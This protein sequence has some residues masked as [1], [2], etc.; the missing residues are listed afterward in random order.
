MKIVLLTF[1][2]L[3]ILVFVSRAQVSGF[4]KSADSLM[5][6]LY[7]EKLFSGRVLVQKSGITLY[8]GDF[9]QISSSSARYKIGSVSKVCTAIMV[10]QLIEEGKLSE[11]MTIE[12]FFPD[13]KYAS[14]ITVEQ[15]LSHSSGI[16][17]IT[18]WEGYYA[19]RN[20]Q[21]S[22]QEILDLIGAHKPSFKP[23]EDCDYSN[24]NYI[25]LGYMMEDITGKT[26]AANLK[27]RVA[28]PLGLKDTYCEVSGMQ[29]PERESSWIFDGEEWQKDMDSDPSLP[30]SAGA[31]VSTTEDLARMMSALFHGEL[32]SPSSL[33][34]MQ[35]LKSKSVGHGI[36]KAPFYEHEGWGHT[37]RIDEFRAFAGYF[38]E[39]S[40]TL[41]ITSNGMSAPLNDIMIGLLSA[42]FDKEYAYPEVFPNAP[43]IPDA[44]VFTGSYKAKL[45]GMFTVGRFRLYAAGH[46]YLFM[47]E[48]K[49]EGKLVEKVLLYRTGDMSF[50]SRESGGA[51]EFVKNRKGNVTKVYIVQKNFRLKCKKYH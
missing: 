1:F 44:G 17:N 10:Y 14:S 32:I 27:E 11:D 25:L 43:Q 2:A 42:Y 47:S 45:L 40:L 22:R 18:S 20:K 26:Y 30:F 15:L 5:N 9:N 23:G 28:D 8:S 48:G 34:R 49:D 50:L 19:S 6:F 4:E 16:Y 12:S 36:F 21:F 35:L 24:S 37:G 41:I 51:M 39:D 33:A 13:L 7:A 29:M 38:P 31:I 3:N 46:N